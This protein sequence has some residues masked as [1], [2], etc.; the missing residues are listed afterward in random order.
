VSEPMVEYEVVVARIERS[1][2]KGTVVRGYTYPSIIRHEKV[3]TPRDPYAQIDTAIRVLEV[4]AESHPEDGL[5]Y[6]E[7]RAWLSKGFTK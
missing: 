5:P 6:S 2:E 1:I 3:I 7:W 4:N